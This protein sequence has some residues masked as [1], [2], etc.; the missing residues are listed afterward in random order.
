MPKG[1][2]MRVSESG[3]HHLVNVESSKTLRKGIH[4]EAGLGKIKVILS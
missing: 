1:F 4:I 2:W 3:F